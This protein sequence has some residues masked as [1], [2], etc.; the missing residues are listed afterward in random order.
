MLL[1]QPLIEG[2]LEPGEIAADTLQAWSRKSV[3]GRHLA[4]ENSDLFSIEAVAL[5]ARHDMYS[6]GTTKLHSAIFSND[7]DQAKVLLAETPIIQNLPTNFLGQSALHL[8]VTQPKLLRWML[9]HVMDSG[10]DIKDNTGS[11]PLI[12][13][14]AYQQMESVEALLGRGANPWIR[15]RFSRMDFWQYAYEVSENGDFLLRSLE[16]FGRIKPHGLQEAVAWCLLKII[17]TQ[18]KRNDVLSRLFLLSVPSFLSSVDEFGNSLLHFCG[19]E[20]YA[21]TLLHGEVCPWDVQN[22][23]G[24]T[25]LMVLG[26][27]FYVSAIAALHQKGVRSDLVD[28]WGMNALHHFVDEG[29]RSDP[30][31]WL[32]AFAALIRTGVD[33]SSG[34]N[35]RCPCS[36]NG[37]SPIRGLFW[38]DNGLAFDRERD[39]RMVPGLIEIGIILKYA[40]TQCEFERAVTDLHRFLRFQELDMTHTCFKHSP[41]DHAVFM[42]PSIRGRV[43]FFNPCEPHLPQQ[44]FPPQDRHERPD[45]VDKDQVAFEQE[46]F[47]QRLQEDCDQFAKDMC[48]DAE[49]LWTSLI[50]RHTVMLEY[51]LEQEFEKEKSSRQERRVAEFPVVPDMTGKQIVHVCYPQFTW[52]KSSHTDSVYVVQKNTSSVHFVDPQKDRFDSTSTDSLTS[53]PPPKKNRRVL[54]SHLDS[55]PDVGYFKNLVT[56]MYDNKLSEEAKVTTRHRMFSEF[57]KELSRLRT[58]LRDHGPE[59]MGWEAWEVDYTRPNLI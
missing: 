49:T 43:K 23:H 46:G 30:W 17:V 34:D 12:Y 54:E 35:C 44:R 14:A 33:T 2:G 8:S 15:D 38:L 32:P 3:V 41:H 55:Y 31:E 28:E 7:F 47:T 45:E 4:I 29:L 20:Q 52:P 24:Y 19:N 51:K 48:G 50:A 1:L 10:I 37:C 16:L 18:V 13:A 6:V 40:R 57:N 42:R 22:R 53:T 59:S 36:V 9:R 11:T 56:I 5:L 27:K 25:P 58:R 26:R 21:L 39:L